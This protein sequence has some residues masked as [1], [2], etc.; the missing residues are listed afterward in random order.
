MHRVGV[1]LSGCGRYDGSDAQETVL[2]SAEVR[3]Q[4][5]RP[6]FLAPD[7][8]Q[9]D[10]VDHATGS[11]VD[12]ATPR[13]VLGEAARLVR[14]PVL[15]V[16]RVVASEIDAL[17]IPGGAGVVK[18]LC[19]PGAG[20]LG[21]GDLR[22]EVDTLLDALTSR[23]APVAVVGLAQLVVARHHRRSLENAP[24]AV[25]PSEVIADEHERVLFT[26]GFMGSDD[27]SEVATGLQRLVVRLADW[28]RASRRTP[29]GAEEA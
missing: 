15:S 6:V 5:M 3:R 16:A 9:A 12:V 27:L 17:V 22:P 1:L 19:L 28:L 23:G 24:V 10:V 4:G 21:G 8:E 14:G 25:P 7:V 20:P 18:N 11:V 29:A 26:P 2:L 13:R